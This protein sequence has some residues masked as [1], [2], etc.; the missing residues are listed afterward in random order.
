MK[1][2]ILTLNKETVNGRIYPR[3]LMEREISRLQKEI[4]KK[5]LLVDLYNPED[6]RLSLSKTIGV[7]NEL[8]IENDVV[9]ADVQFFDEKLSEDLIKNN[10]NFSLTSGVG[11][12]DKSGK[13]IDY[14]MT[15]I[16]LNLTI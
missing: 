7:V 15:H 5:K 16:Y 1:A 14:E 2:N 4:E 10:R 11:K 12:L 9:I 13:V 6:L 8:K 3:E